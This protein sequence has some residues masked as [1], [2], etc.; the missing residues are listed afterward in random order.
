VGVL[1]NIFANIYRYWTRIGRN[2]EFSFAM[3]GMF[4]KLIPNLH[5][6]FTTNISS[7]AF[8]FQKTTFS[9]TT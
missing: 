4:H 6:V 7:I 2:G 3:S 8:Q 9:R 1:Q 5:V